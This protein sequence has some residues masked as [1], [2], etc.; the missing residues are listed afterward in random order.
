MLFQVT[1]ILMYTQ[2]HPEIS[3]RMNLIKVTYE[4]KPSTT[5]YREDTIL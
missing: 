4:A 2:F 1:L 5:K 3:F